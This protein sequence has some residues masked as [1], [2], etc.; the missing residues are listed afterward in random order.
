MFVVSHLVENLLV[1]TFDFL[2]T[3]TW[4][5]HG[6]HVVIGSRQNVMMVNVK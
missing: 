4:E 2:E 1:F 6:G 5:G 3:K